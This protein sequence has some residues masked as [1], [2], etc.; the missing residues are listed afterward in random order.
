MDEAAVATL[1]REGA[2]HNELALLDAGVAAA[3]GK[4]APLVA[5]GLWLGRQGRWKE[6]ARDLVEACKLEPADHYPWFLSAT[7]L[8]HLADE[9]AYRSHRRKMLQ[10]FSET[11]DAVI[12]E[13]IAKVSLLLP[14]EGEDLKRAV[15]LAER[16]R[17]LS[18]LSVPVALAVGLAELRQGRFDA[19][20]DASR[21]A[22]DKAPRSSFLEVT[23]LVIEALA[24]AGQG[25]KDR[26]AAILEKVRDR[27]TGW[28]REG[29]DDLGPAWTD[30]L[31]CRL[32]LRQAETLLP[33]KGPR[34][35][36]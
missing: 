16:A 3:P 11:R 9:E 19:A 36:G 29:K 33:S 30:M 10:Q 21:S 18:G 22:G 7:L 13:R 35:G 2:K 34:T 25:K 17:T 31:I 27:M 8:A 1:V 24:L 15:G 12:A 28:P 26:C 5:R 23:S 32:L 6:A 14:A 20:L 4:A